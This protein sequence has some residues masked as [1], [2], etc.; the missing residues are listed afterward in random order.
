MYN[1]RPD[2]KCPAAV[3]FKI[4]TMYL[5]SASCEGTGL[6]D[7]DAHY[8]NKKVSNG[9]PPTNLNFCSYRVK[10]GEFASKLGTAGRQL[11]IIL[12]SH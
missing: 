7:A 12:L 8:K 9:V 4:M 5:C 11:A 3:L 6:Q 1:W 10:G 2:G